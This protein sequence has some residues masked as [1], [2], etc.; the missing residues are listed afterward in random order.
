MAD[1]VLINQR[2]SFIDA[3]RQLMEII[4]RSANEAENMKLPRRLRMEVCVNIIKPADVELFM[5]PHSASRGKMLHEL[6]RLVRAVEDECGGCDQIILGAEAYE[7]LAGELQ[8]EIDEVIA[9]A[10]E[11]GDE[12]LQDPHAA[13]ENELDMRIVFDAVDPHRMMPLPPT[14]V[15]FE[16]QDKL[17]EIELDL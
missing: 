6:R 8:E 2:H 3:V 10:K 4:V 11:H 13:F 1:G 12:Q 9:R 17:K 16:K 14:K 5:L 15:A 7:L